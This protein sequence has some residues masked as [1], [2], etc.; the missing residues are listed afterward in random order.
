[1]VT[2]AAVK[3]PAR[4]RFTVAEYRAMAEAG[5][6]G[7]DDRV[8]LI[9]GEIYDMPPIG[10]EHGFSTDELANGFK[11]RLGNRVRVRTQSPLH[12]EDGSEPEPD[13]ALLRPPASRY[14]GRHPT[15]ADVLLLVEVSSSTLHFDRTHKLRLYARHGIPE[16]WIVDLIDG[17]IETYA[18][19]ADGQYRHHHVHR[20]GE[21][22]APQAFPDCRLAVDQVLGL[23]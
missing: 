8:E 13:V 12:L 9:E 22:L 14:R 5:I 20:R 18:D 21:E 15:P 16:V 19:P 3:E 11:E 2:A 4:H 1:M 23:S 10:P 7:E 6:F 17:L